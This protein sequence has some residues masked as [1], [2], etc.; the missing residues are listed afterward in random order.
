MTTK[1]TSRILAAVLIAGSLLAHAV[2]EKD[3][4][5]V[6]TKDSAITFMVPPG[7]M[8][9][10]PNDPALK[11]AYDKIKQDNPKL[12]KMMSNEV[13]N[14]EQT[15]LMYDLNDSPDDGALD[16]F[17]VITKKN[18]GITDKHLGDVGKQIVASLPSVGKA[19]YK[20]IDLPF[21]KAVSYWG[22]IDM[23]FPDGSQKKI[24]L[25]GY[26]FLKGDKLHVVSFATGEAQLKEKRKTFE[27]IVKSAKF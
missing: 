9:N 23:K 13:K 6:K 22:T 4:V 16:N 21:G 26:M 20:V 27:G 14:D 15:L 8:T 18:P 7:F 3:W 12:A 5:K 17:N 25:L 24:D 1:W 11:A 10:D 2:Q 19:E